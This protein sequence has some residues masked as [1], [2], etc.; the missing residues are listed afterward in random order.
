MCQKTKS[1][2]QPPLEMQHKPESVLAGADA[3]S[4]SDPTPHEDQAW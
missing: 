2:L 4:W 3:K 1:K